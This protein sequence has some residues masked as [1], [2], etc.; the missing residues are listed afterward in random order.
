MVDGM[1]ERSKTYGLA[2]IATFDLTA[3]TQ[4]AEYLADLQVQGTLAVTTVLMEKLDEQLSSLSQENIG[5]RTQAEVGYSLLVPI[6]RLFC[7]MR[8]V[9]AFASDWSQ[10]L[11][12]EL[13]NLCDMSSDKRDHMAKA[14]A[15]MMLTTSSLSAIKI[16]QHW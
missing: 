10:M 8:G 4:H 13:A 11:I 7:K 5:G 3:T 12:V 16:F 2:H 9:V 14:H 1:S 15:I 6:A